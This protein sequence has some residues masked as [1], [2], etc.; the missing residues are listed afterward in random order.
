[1]RPVCLVNEESL[2]ML[3]ARCRRNN[4]RQCTLVSERSAVLLGCSG[5]GSVELQ[6]AGSADRRPCHRRHGHRGQAV[7][8]R[9]TRAD[10]APMMDT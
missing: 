5:S 3:S 4:D 2:E 8:L 1:M 6:R 10:A 9:F 7:P